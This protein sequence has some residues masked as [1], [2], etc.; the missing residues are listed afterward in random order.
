[1]H[2]LVKAESVGNREPT[3]SALPKLTVQSMPAGSRTAMTA[4]L[5]GRATQICSKSLITAPGV[6]CSSPTVVKGFT[7][8]EV[9]CFVPAP[10]IGLAPRGQGQRF[11]SKK[12]G[13][14]VKSPLGRAGAIRAGHHI[15]G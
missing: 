11:E 5:A 1:M 4:P 7:G 2:C 6:M 9:C 13:L 8:S 12:R 15:V 14:R 10:G 3:E